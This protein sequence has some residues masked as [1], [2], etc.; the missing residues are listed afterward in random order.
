M[1]TLFSM[2]SLFG[3]KTR[4]PRF[5]QKSAVWSKMTTSVLLMDKG[6]QNAKIFGIRASIGMVK[7]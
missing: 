7:R 6:S 1:T 4:P 2:L 5:F 3:C